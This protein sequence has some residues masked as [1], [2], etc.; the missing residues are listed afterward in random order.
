MSP[1]NLKLRILATGHLTQFIEAAIHSILLARCVYPQSNIVTKRRFGICVRLCAES[2]IRKYVANFLTSL[3]VAML[4]DRIH[5]I[6]ILIKDECD[7]SA[8]ER[9]VVEVPNDFARTLFHEKNS[10]GDQTELELA[11]K[12]ARILS[13]VY[14]GLE[15]RLG[16]VREHSIS[17]PTWELFVDM[18]QA[19]VGA[20]MLD[21]PIGCTLLDETDENMQRDAT[22][23]LR[24]P[25]T[26]SSV[27]DKV[28]VL[29]Y[30]DIAER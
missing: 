10:I 1:E 22:K 12:A 4:D 30:V 28:L 5:A 13:E 17:E 2:V 14:R 3:R 7:T 8:R 18:K 26:S 21:V 19:V 16:L 27:N 24:L 25:L 6:W 9:F 15:R 11:C 20:D 23:L 29:T